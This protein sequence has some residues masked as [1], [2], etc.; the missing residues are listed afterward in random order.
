MTPRWPHGVVVRPNAP[1]AAHTARRT[2]G[3]CEAFVV[4]H[5]REALGDAVQ[6]IRDAGWSQTVLGAGTRTVVRD[7]GLAGAVLRLGTGF[8]GLSRDALRWDAGAALP[9]GA[10]VAATVG[11][12]HGGLEELAGVPGTLG[13][14]LALDPGPGRGWGGVV[15]VVYFLNRGRIREGTLEEALKPRSPVIVGARFLLDLSDRERLEARVRARLAASR[16]WSWYAAPGRVDP[17]KLLGQASVGGVRLR[18]VMVPEA[19]PEMMVNLGGAT[20]A[21]L[22][23][24]E[25]SVVDRVSRERGVELKGAVRWA[26]RHRGGEHGAG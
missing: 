9:V 13:A 7:G 2:G 22:A 19:A 17:R 6:A 10:L 15:E 14:A 8:G 11:A 20:A 23:L 5:A 16:A 12:G 18:D 26:G 1:L 24:L 21:D 4:V 3:P 25:R